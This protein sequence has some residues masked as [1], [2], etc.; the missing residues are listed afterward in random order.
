MTTLSSENFKK[1]SRCHFSLITLST[2]PLNLLGFEIIQRLDFFIVNSLL[3]TRER[4]NPGRLRRESVRQRRSPSE[5]RHSLRPA[6]SRSVGYAIFQHIQITEM[7]HRTGQC[8]LAA[9]VQSGNHFVC[10]PT[11]N[12]ELQLWIMLHTV[13]NIAVIFIAEGR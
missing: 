5:T 13:E 2:N 3:A 9:P 8:L 4:I 1:C 11:R 7:F 12:I 6:T 10:L